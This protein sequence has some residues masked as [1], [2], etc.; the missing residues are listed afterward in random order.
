[1]ARVV[2]FKILDLVYTA[3]GG[4]ARDSPTASPTG[5]RVDFRITQ[6]TALR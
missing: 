1:M 6:S 4:A 3:D 5:D 2:S